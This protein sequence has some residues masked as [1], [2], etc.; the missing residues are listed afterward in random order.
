MQLVDLFNHRFNHWHIFLTTTIFLKNKLIMCILSF[1]C[2]SNSFQYIIFIPVADL[3]DLSKGQE[4][5]IKI[6]NTLLI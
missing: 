1:E 5:F 2:R 4:L 6:L 3:V